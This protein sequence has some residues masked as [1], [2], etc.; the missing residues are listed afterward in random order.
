[1]TATRPELLPALTLAYVGDAVHDLY[2]R[3]WL[4]RQ[5]GA[6]PA[7]RLHRAA[8]AY[9]RAG[10]QAAALRALLPELSPVEADIVRRG[11][12]ARPAHAPRGADAAEYQAATAFEALVGY[13][14]LSGQRE[15][16]R[17]V[18]ARAVAHAGEGQPAR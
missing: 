8:T 11:R 12:N 1:M 15:R 7:G 17:A 3:E 6:Q 16:L 13:L 18:L 10:A 4:V 2:V 9:V 14:Y 5:G